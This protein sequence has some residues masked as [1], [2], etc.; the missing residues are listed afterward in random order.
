MRFIHFLL[1]NCLNCSHVV[2]IYC[3]NTWELS[4]CK[5]FKRY[6]DMCRMDE[7]KCG[8]EARHFSPKLVLV[9]NID[10]N[11]SESGVSMELDCM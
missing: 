11:S 7:G 1:A 10:K 6:A 3:E 5:K 4:E 8:K 2:P 9:K